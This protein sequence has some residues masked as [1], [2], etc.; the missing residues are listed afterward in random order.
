MICISLWSCVARGVRE[1]EVRLEKHSPTMFYI[2]YHSTTIHRYAYPL[3]GSSNANAL[4]L[5]ILMK[6]PP[7][8]LKTTGPI[9]NPF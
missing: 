4:A 2:I 8:V 5:G 1:Q 3:L 6:T 7:I 9:M